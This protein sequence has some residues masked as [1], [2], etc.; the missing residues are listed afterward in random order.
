MTK[1]ISDKAESYDKSDQESIW[2]WV[3]GFNKIALEIFKLFKQKQRKVFDCSIESLKDYDKNVISD[4][5]KRFM[6]N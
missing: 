5:I 3:N 4:K 6:S 2:N 1:L